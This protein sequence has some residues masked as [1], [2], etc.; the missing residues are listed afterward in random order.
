MSVEEWSAL[1]KLFKKEEKKAF[2]T[3]YDQLWSRLYSVAYNYVRDKATAQEIVQDVF[4]NLWVKRS[5]LEFVNDITAYV[6]RAVKY[7]IY[8]YFDKKA[9]I[10]RYIQKISQNENEQ[11]V[12]PDH[13]MEFDETFNRI[14][15]EIGKLPDTTQRIFRLSRFDQFSNEEIA[16][17]LHI[18]V[19]TVEYHITQSLKHLRAQ[20]GYIVS[21][22][23]PLSV[24][25]GFPFA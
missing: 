21:I 19:K 7:Q 15:Q 11:V 10:D 23:G 13:Q 8:D 12:G 2:Q 18:S 17:Q 24:L 3:L 25:L 20:L 6:M 16:S 14:S 9:V 5:R 22:G 4:V 1:K